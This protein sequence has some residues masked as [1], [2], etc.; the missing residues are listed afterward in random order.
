[1]CCRR[2]VLMVDA[3]SRKFC[4]LVRFSVIM[5]R[6]GRAHKRV[7]KCAALIGSFLKFAFLFFELRR[8]SNKFVPG[9]LC[10]SE[11][12]FAVGQKVLSWLN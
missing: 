10:W 11:F 1:M 5:L 12:S 8:V 7:I 6:A 3:I 2:S 9:E 4:I